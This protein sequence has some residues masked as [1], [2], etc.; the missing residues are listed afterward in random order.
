MA[1]RRI[2]GSADNTEYFVLRDAS[3]GL[4]K[5]DCTIT[6]VDIYYLEEGAAMAAKVDCT[7]LAAATTAHTDN[8]GYNVGL[9]L[10]RVDFPDAAYDGGVDKQVYLILVHAS[11]I[12]E[13]K[14]ILLVSSTR[15]L[16]GTGLPDA[17]AGATNG[18]FIA[19]TNAA[20]TVTTAFTANIT[21]N[22]SGSVGSVAA[23]GINNA[24]LAADVGSTA[25][26]TNIIAL[27]VRKVLDEL[28]LDHLVKVPV[29][30][31]ADMTTEV[32]DGTIV[33]NMIT[34]DGDTSDYVPATDSLEGMGES[35]A[36]I[37]ADTG[38]DGVKLAPGAL[39][40]ANCDA[41]IKV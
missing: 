24:S 19:G 36:A 27:A 13:F 21:G 9:G 35:V 6:D 16:S 33:S 1:F 22:V 18:V 29:A 7:A 4:P 17:I 30:S 28:N 34:K 26:A 20:T 40:A 23:G 8:Y 31:N 15:G 38:T 2:N 32:P 37:L 12:T 3:T 11:C 39:G 14:E 10:Y 25:Y 41:D 5:A